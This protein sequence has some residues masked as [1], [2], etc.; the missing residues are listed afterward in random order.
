[1]TPP[2][3]QTNGVVVE[4]VG[5]VDVEVVGEVDICHVFSCKN[6]RFAEDTVRLFSCNEFLCSRKKRF[7]EESADMLINIIDLR[8]STIEWR[9][10]ND[11]K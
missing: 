3:R 1:M 11:K 9:V 2:L 4:V 8:Q 10:M 6:N 7:T 5:V